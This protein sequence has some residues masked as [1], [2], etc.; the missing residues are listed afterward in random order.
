RAALLCRFDLLTHPRLAVARLHTP[1]RDRIE[2]RRCD[3]LAGAQAEA[4]MMP[5][6]PH[7]VRDHQPVGER[8]A[9][10][11]AAR[12]DREEFIAAACEQHGFLA[13]MSA[14]H[15]AVSELIERDAL[16]EVRTTRLRWLAHG[17]LLTERKP[18]AGLSYQS[19]AGKNPGGDIRSALVFPNG[20]AELGAA[21]VADH[22]RGKG[23]RGV[24]KAWSD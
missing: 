19:Q 14:D 2:R 16:R 17:R 12:S 15:A 21:G 22:V 23:L 20:G 7:G 11:R 3:R 6:T 4:G 9:I 13:D 24:E 5:W 10:V 1:A 18:R 8:P